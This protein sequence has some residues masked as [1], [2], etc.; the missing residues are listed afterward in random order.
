MSQI[1]KIIQKV[2]TFIKKLASSVP[3]NSKVHGLIFLALNNSIIIS[4]TSV[5]SNNLI[6]VTII[7]LE[8]CK[9]N[10]KDKKMVL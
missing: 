6:D 9:S 5:Q 8:Y 10:Q 2:H 1:G 4:H 3:P 7:A